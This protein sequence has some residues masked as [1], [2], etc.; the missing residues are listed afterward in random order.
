[1]NSRR[2][3]QNAEWRVPM[4]SRVV[5]LTEKQNQ[6]VENKTHKRKDV[7]VS[8]PNTFARYACY[9][10]ELCLEIYITLSII[11]SQLTFSD[12]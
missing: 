8:H 3:T 6:S 4:S 11:N 5:E 2:L 1:M 9:K 10:R 12:C 7:L